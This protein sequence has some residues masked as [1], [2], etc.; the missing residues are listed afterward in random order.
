VLAAALLT[1]CGISATRHVTVQTTMSP[2]AALA[3]GPP[4][5]IAVI[6]MENEEYGDVIGSRQTPFI[7]A[8][9]GRYALAKAMY[10][11]S[12]PS[13]PNYLALTGGS[14]FGI[15][16]DCTDC[17]VNATGLADQLAGAHLSWTAYMEDL[18]HPCYGGA[19]AGEYA[20]RH[21]PVRV[22]HPAAHP[23]RAV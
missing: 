12:H 7:N 1:A 22:L 16:S 18:P 20:K 2:T 11:T 3:G 17:S 21:D 23:P 13:L 4:A 19:G 8:L 9:A 14:T 6:V 10:A 15:T 5:H